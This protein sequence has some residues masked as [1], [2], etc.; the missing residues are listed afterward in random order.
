MNQLLRTPGIVAS[1]STLA[2]S[3]SYPLTPL[4]RPLVLTLITAGLRKGSM[5]LAAA[6]SDTSMEDGGG[7]GG[8]V[9]YGEML[10]ALLR[11]INLERGLADEVAM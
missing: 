4:L 5:S 1:L 3:T 10:T 11:E 6:S 8:P 9:H 7:G 2:T